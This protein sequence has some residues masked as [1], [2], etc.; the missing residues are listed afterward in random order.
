MKQ[1]KKYTYTTPTKV[2]TFELPIKLSTDFELYFA[3]ADLPEELRQHAT[4]VILKRHKFASFDTLNETV[5]KIIADFETQ[6][7]EET[8]RKVILYHI[9]YRRP[10]QRDEQQ[11]YFHFRVVQRIESGKQTRYYEERTARGRS[12]GTTLD[13]FNT[14]ELMNG[15]HREEPSEM[16]WTAERELW[17]TEMQKSL[18]R[19]GQQL[20]EGFGTKPEVLARKID[21]DGFLQLISNRSE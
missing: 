17:F 15:D 16:L 20:V 1:L 13:E 14:S 5:L 12:L 9:D 18:H 7:V 21:Q 6:F 4:D 2:K 8:R 3:S 11:I 19:L 10:S